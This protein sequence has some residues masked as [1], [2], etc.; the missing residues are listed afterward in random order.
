MPSFVADGAATT[1]ILHDAMS[2]QVSRDGLAFWVES[3]DESAPVF[4]AGFNNGV[5]HDGSVQ[6]YEA[7]MRD[8]IGDD[9]PFIL[10]AHDWL[11]DRIPRLTTLEVIG[12]EPEEKRTSY[13]LESLTMEEVIEI[14]VAIGEEFAK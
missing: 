1:R 13:S 3:R 4:F 9:C 8:D 2:L 11:R 14:L 6:F 5:E 12:R 7:S 10:W